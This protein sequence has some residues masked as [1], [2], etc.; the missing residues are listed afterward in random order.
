MTGLN[1]NDPNNQL[2]VEER[3]GA[4]AL[5]IGDTEIFL[6]PQQAMDI[7]GILVQYGHHAQTGFDAP[8]RKIVSD[9][10]RNKLGVRVALVAKNL[11]E[12]K[13]SPEFIAQEVV[14]IVLREVM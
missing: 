5:I 6:P 2:S 11:T 10:I 8:T 14:D 4:V 12:R 13:K 7:G 3:S 9:R 1:G